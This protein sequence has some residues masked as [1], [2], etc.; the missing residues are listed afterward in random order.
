VYASSAAA[1][2][3]VVGFEV[4]WLWSAVSFFETSGGAYEK[5]IRQPVMEKHFDA[6]S[7]ST[8]GPR[9]SGG[10]SRRPGAV[11]ASSPK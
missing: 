9:L 8:Y 3:G 7:I 10:S 6:P 4:I 1:C 5:P 2:E 11:S